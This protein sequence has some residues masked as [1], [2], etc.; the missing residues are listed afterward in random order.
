M[1][2]TIHDAPSGEY[3]GQL[4]NQFVLCSF[5]QHVPILL[6]NSSF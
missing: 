1:M 2:V 5:S 4:K 3:V 6:V